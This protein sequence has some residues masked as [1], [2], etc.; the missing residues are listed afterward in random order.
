MNE[1]KKTNKLSDV[2]RVGEMNP[3]FQRAFRTPGVQSSFAEGRRN[4]P[5][6]HLLRKANIPRMECNICKVFRCS[7]AKRGK[8]GNVV[9]LKTKIM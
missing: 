9:F 3:A 2:L 6:I 8:Y 5:V 1:N 7:A 4:I